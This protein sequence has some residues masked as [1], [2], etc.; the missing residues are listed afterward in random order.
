MWWQWCHTSTFESQIEGNAQRA[1][2]HVLWIP[3]GDTLKMAYLEEWLHAS[4]D[5]SE[6]Q[7]TFYVPMLIRQ[8]A[9]QFKRE[10]YEG[11]H[12][13]TI[14]VTAVLQH[15]RDNFQEHFDPGACTSW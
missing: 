14:D 2:L 6:E 15:E 12:G 8:V 7:N 5:S 1:R 10:R 13:V 9:R 11:D 3:T 4:G